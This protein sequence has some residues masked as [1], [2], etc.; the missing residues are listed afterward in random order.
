MTVFFSS[1]ALHPCSGWLTYGGNALYTIDHLRDMSRDP[2]VV[3]EEL[4][5]P[6]LAQP[7][8]FHTDVDTGDILTMF[9]QRPSLKGGDQFIAPMAS[10]YNDLMEHNPQAVRLLTED[11]FWERAYR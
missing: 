4:K 10:V 7:M 6:E 8:S 11:W 3:V 1:G 5:P 2:A 9:I